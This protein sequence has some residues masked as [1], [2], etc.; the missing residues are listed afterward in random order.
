MTSETRVLLILGA[1]SNTG[2]A[3]ASK[4]LEG[5]YK[6]ALVA[7]RLEPGQS[8]DGM[9]NIRADLTEAQ[10]VVDAF[11]TTR[12]VLGEPNIVVYNGKYETCAA[13]EPWSM[14]D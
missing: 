4:F 3:V 9:L 7:R 11:E 10:A 8:E 6:V 14:R 1:G 5:G 13:E 12:K 2:R